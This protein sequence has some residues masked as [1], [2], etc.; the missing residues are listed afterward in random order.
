MRL[1]VVSAPHVLASQRDACWNR[2]GADS[3]E[4]TWYVVNTGPVCQM[5]EPRN[6]NL[7]PQTGMVVKPHA[8]AI[9][10]PMCAGTLARRVETSNT[11]LLQ[12]PPNFM[13]MVV[14][15]ASHVGWHH[16]TACAGLIYWGNH[17]GSVVNGEHKTNGSMGG[18]H[19]CHH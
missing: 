8:S 1:A 4:G 9:P 11:M 14:G 13:R 3:M 16:S 17:R 2:P 19:E 7:T 10:A 6:V 5:R 12:F 18:D 15:L